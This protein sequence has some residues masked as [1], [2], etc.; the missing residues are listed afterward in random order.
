MKKIIK[1]CFRFSSVKL[2]M[3]DKDEQEA[4]AAQKSK[5]HNSGAADLEKVTDYAE[6]KEIDSGKLTDAM[7]AISDKRK[8]EAESR[9]EREKV[10]ASVKVKKE[11][12][13]VVVNE[14]EISRPR[15]E[16]CLREAGG[17]LKTALTALVNS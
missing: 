16:R 10:L 9:I 2:K 3:T 13:D 6:E 12:I 7:T 5:V 17:D 4:T 15:A 1:I 8:K 11:D 14:F